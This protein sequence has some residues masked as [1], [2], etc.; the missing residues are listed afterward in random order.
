[1]PEWFTRGFSAPR[2][3]PYLAAVGGDADAALR[4]YLWNT[5]VSG[6]FYG[7]LHWAEV[8]L[9]NTLHDNLNTYF[10]PKVW[11][12]S[13]PL[14]DGT[15]R[16][17]QD[18]TTLCQR[19][20]PRATTADDI[21]SE[22][23]FGHWVGLLAS[24]YDRTLWVPTLHDAFPGYRGRRDH[25]HTRLQS[26]LKLRNRI[27]H[28]EPIHHLPLEADHATIYEVLRYV[29]P[30]AARELRSYDQLPSILSQRPPRI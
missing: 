29:N 28:H 14:L 2:L 3:K 9:R 21:V 27:S 8:I 13:A 10:G 15:L 18:A 20:H 12:E 22:L 25:L 23:T 11:W 1:M 4:L 5:E 30:D 16:K 6:A 7:P 26:L 24:R 19:K 17:I